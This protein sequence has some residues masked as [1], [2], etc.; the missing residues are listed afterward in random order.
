MLAPSMLAPSA[1]DTASAVDA[2]STPRSLALLSVALRAQRAARAI[3]SHTR[4]VASMRRGDGARVRACAFSLGLRYYEG[5]DVPQNRSEAARLFHLA[6][7]QGHADSQ[8]ILALCYEEGEGVPLNQSEAARYYRLAADQGDAAAQ[9]QLGDCYAKG[10]GVP[11][12][13]I[14]AA[15]YYRLAADQGHDAQ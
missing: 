1:V 8:L 10:K 6:A 3:V 12:S 13:T 14:E 5:E 9:Y 7:D 4:H 2:A 11:R 15:R